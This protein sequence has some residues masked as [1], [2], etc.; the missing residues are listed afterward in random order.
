MSAWPDIPAPYV[1]FDNAFSRGLHGI[2]DFDGMPSSRLMPR[3][4][5]MQNGALPGGTSAGDIPAL[6]EVRGAPPTGEGDYDRKH[7]GERG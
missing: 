6:V 3:I 7:A 4:D 5:L 2:D 1:A